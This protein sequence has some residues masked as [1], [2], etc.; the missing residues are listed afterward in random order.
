MT[1]PDARS[2]T[3]APAAARP[4]Q[5]E[6]VSP[7][8]SYRWVEVW[9]VPIRL[10]HWAA[11]ASIVV[12]FWT[13]L[14]LGRP[15]F[16]TSLGGGAFTVQFARFAHFVAAGVLVAMA[17]LRVYW[18][19]AGN[20]WERWSALFPVRRRNWKNL[21]CS[22][23]FYL[24][25]REPEPERYLG[26]NPLQQLFYTFTYFVGA[27][28][29]VTG[30]LLYAQANPTGTMYRAI[31]WATPLLGGNQ[32]VR[33]IHHVLPWYYP[34]FVIVH[35]YM[36][37]RDDLVERSGMISSIFGGGRLVPKDEHFADE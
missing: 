28:M 19:F 1:T 12:L 7:G 24:F 14:Y 3:T 16:M 2:A 5:P 11:A 22:V 36:A 29:M 18:L 37:I 25:L 21:W 4:A 17:V 26:H 31:G 8:G 34:A 9:G 33:T 6:R 35:A 13:G 27:A 15:Y 10:T 20:K 23:K 30:F 32:V